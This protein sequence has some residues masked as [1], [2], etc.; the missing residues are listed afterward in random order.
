MP[1]LHGLHVLHTSLEVASLVAV[2]GHGEGGKIGCSSVIVGA[3]CAL[4]PAGAGQQTS[5]KWE[6]EKLISRLPPRVHA[7]SDI[8]SQ[9]KVKSHDSRDSTWCHVVEK[10]LRGFITSCQDPSRV[11]DPMSLTTVANTGE[12]GS[13]DL[14]DSLS[15]SQCVSRVCMD[16]QRGLWPRQWRTSAPESRIASAFSEWRKTEA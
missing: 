13:L 15:L 10:T 5:L 8:I 4:S 3:R 1:D 9:S 6:K 11:K 7:E 12:S 16:G 14:L 2:R